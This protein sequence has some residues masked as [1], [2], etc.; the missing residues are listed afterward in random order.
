MRAYELMVIME[1]AL[2]E[3][4][5]E[6]TVRRV[7][8]QVKA[9]GGDVRRT[10]RWGKRR[11]AYEIEKKTDGYYVVIEFVGGEGLADLER[12]FRLADDIVRHKIIRLPDAEAARR[13]LFGEAQETAPAPAG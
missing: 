10:D 6:N 13:G 5:V 9:K 8:E 12:Q 2:D 7:Q 4:D 3:N 11:F 1:G